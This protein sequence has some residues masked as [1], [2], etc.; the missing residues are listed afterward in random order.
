[1]RF[2]CIEFTRSP[3][4]S[5]QADKAVLARA[6]G[7]AAT[8]C[9]PSDRWLVQLLGKW[10]SGEP[11][12]PQADALQAV[13]LTRFQQL[14]AP[15]SAKAVED[16]AFYRYGRLI[17]RNDVGFDPGRLA[18]S[19][20]QFHA[21]M[22]ARHKDFPHALLATATHDHKRGED[23]RARL[24]VLSEVADDWSNAL[25]GWLTLVR[26]HFSPDADRPRLD[27]ADLTFLFQTVIGAWPD[28][29]EPSDQSAMQSFAK[30]IAAWQQK[31]LREAKLRTDWLVPDEAY[32]SAAAEFVARLFAA[33]SLLLSEIVDFARRIAPAGAVNSLAQ[34]LVKLTAPG[35]PDLYQGTEFWD[36]SLVDPD[37]RA[38]VGFAARQQSLGLTDAAKLAAEWKDGRIKQ[39]VIARILAA[40]KKMPDLFERGDYLP[41][42][43]EGPL[44]RHVI[45]F[46]RIF[47][48]SIAVTAFCRHPAA[49]LNG[50]NSILVDQ[51]HWKNTRIVLPAEYR[52][53]TYFDLLTDA[54]IGGE[55]YLDAAEILSRLPIAFLI[56]QVRTN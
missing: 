27:P 40:R 23:V 7:R 29:L 15:L 55:E 18:C 46:A 28:G 54:A 26:E 52:S 25:E 4:H 34:L 3:G 43:I 50:S 47:Q 12:R 37:N 19:A 11:I 30:R 20:D 33:P 44:A 31:A 56:S 8:S 51:Q 16:T 41:L 5:S 32:E 9:L 45:A 53:R 21:R 42:Q 17:S 38:P 1:M 22:Q 24:A 35:V 48:A 36:F 49:L 39:Q 6:V 2:Q 14:S 13:A 10:L